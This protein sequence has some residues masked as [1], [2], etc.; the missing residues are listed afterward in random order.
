VIGKPKDIAKELVSHPRHGP[1]GGKGL[2][3]MKAKERRGSASVLQT[4]L[5]NVQVHAVDTFRFENNMLPDDIADGSW[6]THDAGSDRQ[7]PF[8]D[9]HRLAVRQCAKA[10]LGSIGAPFASRHTLTTYNPMV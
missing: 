2:A 5:I 7:G 1:R 8:T 4:R 10:R 6:Y 9:H 3:P